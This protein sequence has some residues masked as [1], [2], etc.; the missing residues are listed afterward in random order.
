MVVKSEIIEQTYLAFG[1][2]QKLF[3]ETSYLIREIEGLL[4]EEQEEFIIGRP[5]GYHVTTRHS[6]GLEMNNVNN[7]LMRKFSVFFVA[8]DQTEMRQGQTFTKITPNLKIIY[9]KVILNDKTHAR[10]IIY[11]G[12]FYDV[13]IKDGVKWNKIE[14]AMVRLEDNDDKVL[15]NIQSI[16]YDDAYIKFKGKLIKNNLYDINDSETI[17]KKVIKPSLETYRKF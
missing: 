8:G 11:S 12:A 2:I 10:P 16:N 5:S 14:H 7:W 1:F 13:V 4:S 3:L 6:T 9:V 17:I 15:K